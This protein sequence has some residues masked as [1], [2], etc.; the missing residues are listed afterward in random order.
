V[1]LMEENYGG[2]ARCFPTRQRTRS[3]CCRKRSKSELKAMGKWDQ[4]QLGATSKLAPEKEMCHC[5]VA[6]RQLGTY[7]Q[8]HQLVVGGVPRVRFSGVHTLDIKIG[9]K[10]ECHRS[11]SFT[12]SPATMRHWRRTMILGQLER[13]PWF[14]DFYIPRRVLTL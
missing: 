11:S 2:C 7:G 12:S 5:S 8:F 3:G 9:K 14:Y 6:A 10:Y 1:S 4:A 13:M